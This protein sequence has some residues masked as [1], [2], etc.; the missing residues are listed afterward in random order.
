MVFFCSELQ[1]LSQPFF[2]TYILQLT[3]SVHKVAYMDRNLNRIEFRLVLVG[4]LLPSYA[5][6][7]RH[8]WPIIEAAKALL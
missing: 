2:H 1:T 4:G 6:Y 7:N 5:K 3:L 8:L